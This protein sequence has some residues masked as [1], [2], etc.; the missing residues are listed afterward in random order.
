MPTA[1]WLPDWMLTFGPLFRFGPPFRSGPLSTVASGLSVVSAVPAF[2]FADAGTDAEDW[3]TDAYATPPVRT[4]R[5]TIAPIA[6]LFLSFIAFLLQCLG[7][8]FQPKGTLCED[9]VMDQCE[10]LMK[11]GIGNFIVS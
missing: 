1:D 8:C 11:S 3:F 7:V 2:T 10:S 4:G 5:A 6:S 9:D